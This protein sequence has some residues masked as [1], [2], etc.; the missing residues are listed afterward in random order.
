MNKLMILAMLIAYK[1]FNDKSLTVTTNEH[2][3]ND[4]IVNSIDDMFVT[5]SSKCD[6]DDD[7]YTYAININSII[8]IQFQN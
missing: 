8:G 1:A 6:S 4:A 2:V 7:T 3:Y 5:V